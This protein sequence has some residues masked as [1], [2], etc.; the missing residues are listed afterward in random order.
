M[1]LY[2]SILIERDGLPDLPISVTG[3]YVPAVRGDSEQAY[4][5]PTPDEAGYV[6]DLEAVWEDD[7]SHFEEDGPVIDFYCGEP[8]TLTREEEDRAEEAL[9]QTL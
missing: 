8:V 7:V 4:G 2:A 9:L 6:T 5:G 1:T 3:T